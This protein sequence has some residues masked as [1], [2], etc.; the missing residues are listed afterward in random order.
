MYGSED[1]QTWPGTICEDPVDAMRCPPQA[2]TPRV[3]PEVVKKE[4]EEQI[5]DLDWVKKNLPEVSAL[6]W[7]L[8]SEKLPESPLAPEAVKEPEPPAPEPAP[9]PEPVKEALP[10]PALVVKL[11]PDFLPS[12]PALPWWLRLLVRLL[13]RVG[14]KLLPSGGG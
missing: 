11:A 5:K 3:T 6:L 7:V 14:Y 8:G 1:P 9:V 12:S 2:F 13:R 10:D 4:F